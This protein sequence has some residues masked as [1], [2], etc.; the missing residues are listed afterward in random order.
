VGRGLRSIQAAAPFR[1]ILGAQYLNGL[2]CDQLLN[3]QGS[4]GSLENPIPVNG[5]IGEIKYL[6]KL[7]GN[8]G[9][10][11]MFHRIG[12]M[13]SS[14]V[15]NPVDCYEVVCM[16]GTQWNHL[17]FDRYHPRRSNLCPPGYTL[18]LFNKSL[19]MDIP[20]GFGC[21]TLASDFPYSLSDA[22]IS[23]YGESPG[24]AFARRID[25][26]LQVYSFTR[27]TKTKQAVK[28]RPAQ[29]MR[30]LFCNPVQ[31]GPLNPYV[32]RRDRPYQP[33]ASIKHPR[34]EI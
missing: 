34:Q 26:R 5:S 11:L 21:N 3:G 22:I 6:V 1:E 18:V 17:H 27:P 13:G 20:Y 24:R 28:E 30:S 2:D 19:D 29:T 33:L 7:R 23:L 4:F 15:K 9:E 16:D 10:P 8:T 12:S 31:A 32:W 14:V 25:E